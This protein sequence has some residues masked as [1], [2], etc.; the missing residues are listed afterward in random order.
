MITIEQIEAL[1]IGI[2]PID[3]RVQLETEAAIDWMKNNTTLNLDINNPD[4]FPAGAKLFILSYF[5]IDMMRAGIA[6]ESI[7]GLS[8][9]FRDI[10]K[11]AALWG[12]AEQYLSEYLK[13][14]Q[15]KF[16]S[17]SQRWQ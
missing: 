13:G 3:T 14:G 9:S 11:S 17:A 6:S 8:Q 5:D 7:E 12:L 15:V 2:A 16:I 4:T 1:G 10:D